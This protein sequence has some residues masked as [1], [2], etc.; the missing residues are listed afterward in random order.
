MLEVDLESAYR[1]PASDYA[2][3]VP[4]D[5]LRDIDDDAA[6][7]VFKTSGI[8]DFGPKM[9]NSIR[10]MKKKQRR[11]VGLGC[12]LLGLIAAIVGVS[13]A[14]FG[15]SRNEQ[16]TLI[17]PGIDQ[18]AENLN[19]RQKRFDAIVKSSSDG[20]AFLNQ[21]SPQS[22]ARQWLIFNDTLWNEAEEE[23]SAERIQQRYV[24]AV[25]YFGSGGKK[26]WSSNWLSGDEC[27]GWEYLDCDNDGK[28]RA[29]AF[30]NAG[31]T[32]TISAEIAHLK[33]LENIIIKNEQKLEG[34]IPSDLGRLEKLRQV[35]M[36]SRR[37]QI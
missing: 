21:D 35:R 18:N 19:D 36:S 31:L 4:E 32:G 20:L 16:V 6:V 11:R 1:A 27:Q 3:H 30:D 33:L 37:K 2:S 28:V 9:Y 13:V 17:P 8:L 25:F 5:V 26:S 23:I 15:G 7:G 24:L 12:V 22:R 29:I 34:E 10:F 14:G